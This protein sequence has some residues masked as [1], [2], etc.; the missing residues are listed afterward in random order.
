MIPHG[1]PPIF[2]SELKDMRTK[3]G[4]TLSLACHVMVPPW[5][6]SVIWYN[7]EGK[8]ES[9]EKYKLI[10]DGLGAHILEIKPAE[11]CDEGEWKCVVTS[12]EG[13]ISITTCIVH[14]DSKHNVT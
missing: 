3:I 2:T 5:P 9:S 11:F 12:N 7:K 1:P 14:M 10:E 4:D 13:T 6:K 8:V